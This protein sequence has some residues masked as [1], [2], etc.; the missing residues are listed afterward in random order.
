M[1]RVDD[2]RS[3]VLQLSEDE[4]AALA[5]DLLISLD[6]DVDAE[7]DLAWVAEIQAR[8]ETV[9]R[10]EF[11]AC[12]WRESVARVRAELAARRLS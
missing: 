10:G 1:S 8:A 5:R 7:P 4:R 6:G 9:A 11:A 2:L 12:D 3:Q